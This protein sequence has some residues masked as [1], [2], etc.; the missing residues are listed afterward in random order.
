MTGDMMVPLDIRRRQILATAPLLLGSSWLGLSGRRSAAQAVADR[1]DDPT[2][3]TARRSPVFVRHCLASSSSPLATQVGLRVLADGGNAFDAAVAMAG[4]MA[5]VEPMMSGLGGDTM[6]IAWSARERKVVGLNGSGRASSGASLDRV[7]NRPMM[8]ETGPHAVTIPGAVDGWCRLLERFGSR[9][10]AKLWEPA[11]AAARDGFPVGESIAG[12]WAAARLPHFATPALLKLLLPAGKPPVPGQI[13]RFPQLADT[14]D[15]VAR[16]GRTAFYAGPA[17]PRRD[18]DRGGAAR[19][20]FSGA[21]GGR[22]RGPRPS[23]RRSAG[24][25]GC[26][27]DGALASG[28]GGGR[29]VPG[30]GSRSPA[31]R[32]RAGLVSRRGR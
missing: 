28:R 29:P 15:L 12:T 32:G 2:G 23:A 16:E 17:V 10:L 1:P 11:V 24:L 27:A 22:A 21:G 14:L 26:H 9:P 4:M 20:R 13:V 8:P 3:F 18:D 7:G 6:I 30:V 5:V 31:R 25:Q 19:R